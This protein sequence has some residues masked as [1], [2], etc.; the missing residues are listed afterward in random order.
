MSLTTQI[1]KFVKN[2]P[3]LN[4][5]SDSVPKPTIKTI[6]DWYKNADRFAMNPMTGKAWE[7]PDGSGK[8]PTWKACPAIYDIMGTGYVYRTPCDIEFYEDERGSIQCKVLDE[9][10]KDFISI[11]PAMPQ[12]KSP[13]G[14]HENHFAW[15][16]D[17]AVEVPE[18]YSVLYTQPFNRFELPFLTTS[19]IIDNDHVHLPGTMPFFVVKGFTGTL[20]AGT[21]YAQMLPFKRENWSHEI[22][23][24][25][26]HQEMSIK[27]QENSEIYRKPDGGIYQ[28]DVWERRKYD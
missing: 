1:I 20:P 2:R 13:A 22:D 9:N 17:W 16:A 18:G 5:D 14:Y 8:I 28:R 12:F 11:R 24:T 26:S 15:W 23:V 7:M 4:K 19:G 21:P 10:N 6:P 25:I 27:N 3:W